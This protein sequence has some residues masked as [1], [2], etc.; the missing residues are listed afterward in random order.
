MRLYLIEDDSQKAESISQFLGRMHP[1][2]CV[3]LFGSYQSGL[4]AIER[5]APDLIVL[6][7]NL[8]TF[9]NLGALRGGRPRALGGYEILR[10][11]RRKG[12]AVPVVVITQ[13][14]SFGDGDSRVSFAEII[15]RCQNE[16]PQSFLGG[17]YY[18]RLSDAWQEEVRLL[19][20]HILEQLNA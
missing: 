20:A 6:D 12:L 16:F 14:E 8:P 4:K 10:K 3:E 9:D 19:L 1:A 11:M 2:V 18:S 17:V 7:M 5:D 13:L 15:E